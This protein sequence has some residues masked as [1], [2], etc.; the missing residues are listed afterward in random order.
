MKKKISKPLRKR[1][2]RKMFDACLTREE[3]YR[4]WYKRTMLSYYKLLALS[5]A[6]VISLF[7]TLG[8]NSLMP[9]SNLSFG[10]VFVISGTIY[11]LVERGVV[12]E[13]WKHEYDTICRIETHMHEQIMRSQP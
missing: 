6:V 9:M 8:A 3:R 10:L 12:C 13:L 2:I 1:E 4:D 7:T 5:I 11:Y